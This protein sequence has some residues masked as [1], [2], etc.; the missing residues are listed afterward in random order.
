VSN[1]KE[2]PQLQKFAALHFAEH[3]EE[4]AMN[5][6]GFESPLQDFSTLAKNIIVK[7]KQV[8]MPNGSKTEFFLAFV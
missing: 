6:I 3:P 2:L 1:Q 8:C 5:F 7:D 4:S